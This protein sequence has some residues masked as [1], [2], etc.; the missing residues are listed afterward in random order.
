MFT[1]QILDRGQTL[2]FPLDR[3]AVQFGSGASAELVLGEEGV[4]ALHARFV[5]HEKGVRLEPLAATRVNGQ[6]LKGPAELALGDRIELGRAV[7]VVGRTVARAATADDVLAARPR[8][9]ESAPRRP[10]V[11]RRRPA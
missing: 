10:V 2:L 9:G 4:A 8:T 6:E 7:L 5:P 11:R 3:R 1:L